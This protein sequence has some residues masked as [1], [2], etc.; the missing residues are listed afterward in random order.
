MKYIKFFEEISQD[1]IKIARG[2]GA[3]LGEMT[4]A[5]F[6]IPPGF[7]VLAQA[8]EK[9][10]EETDINVEIEATLKKVDP[11]KLIQLMMLLKI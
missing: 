5:K 9:F 7:V 1:D 11:K 10:L 4:T 6:P 8:F 2:K 3:S